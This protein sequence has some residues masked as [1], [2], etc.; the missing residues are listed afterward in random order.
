MSK[1]QKKLERAFKLIKRDKTDDALNIL[2]PIIDSEPDNIDAWWLL[3]YASTEP[4]EV[5]GAL[6]R[7]LRLDP[8]YTN[9]PKA[10]EMLARLNQ[11]YPPDA[12]EIAAY[13]ELQ[14]SAFP[15]VFEADDDLFPEGDFQS[16]GIEFE[17]EPGDATAPFA[18]DIFGDTFEPS[19]ETQ[20]DTGD[21]FA[22]EDPFSVM[23]ET[24]FVSGGF[25]DEFEENSEAIFAP[26][27]PVETTSIQFESEPLDEE[28]RATQEERAFRKS[29]RGKRFIRLFVG[30]V[31][32][33]A[34]VA[35]LLLL[36]SLG[37]DGEATEPV[38]L[39]AVAVESDQIQSVLVAVQDQLQRTGFGAGSQALIAKSDLGDTLFA[40]VCTSP[41]RSLPQI[42]NESMEIVASQASNVQEELDAVGVTITTCDGDKRD[43]LYRAF[44]SVDNVMRYLNGELDDGGA[45]TSIIQARFQEMWETP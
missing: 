1:S 2:R 29:E 17:A 24:P 38:E 20:Q 45:D 5:R 12:D 37:S 13:P 15:D 4:Q 25:E 23:G 39:S 41:D 22:E 35:V 7:V 18:E 43:T 36:V 31:L 32:I 42:I 10:R 19:L 26:P 34:V 33:A 14:T 27:K 8:N 28:A 16:T 9:A 11:E 6:L 3:A 21:I 40:E 30:L 44:V